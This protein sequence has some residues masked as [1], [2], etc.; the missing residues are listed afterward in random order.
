MTIGVVA[1]VFSGADYAVFATTLLISCGIG[2]YHA[3][4]GGRQRTSAEFF[5]A[6]RSMNPV[7]VAVSLVASFISAI[8]FLGTPAENYIH[9]CMFWLYGI[10]YV[11]TGLITWRC[12]M[13]VF[14][15]LHVT[16]AF[17]YLELRFNKVLR[18]CGM[19]TF[20]LQMIIYMGIVIY[21]PALALSAVTGLHL[22]GS[23]VAIG[24]VCTFYTTIGGMKAVL[25]TDVFQVCIMISGFLA[26][27]IAG[28]MRL[29]G[30]TNVW[31]IAEEGGRIDFFNFDPDPT[32]R[33]TF[34]SVVVGGTFTWS[35]VYCVNQAQ[36][37]RYLT[38]G[39]EPVAQLALFMAVVGMVIVVSLA[40]LAGLVMYANYAGCDPYTLKY[41]DS[42]DQLVPYFLM[43]LFHESPGLPGLLVSAV[44][45][46]ALSTVSSG[47]NSLAAVTGED[48]VKTIRPNI[49]EEKYTKITKCLAAGYGLLCIGMAF[50]ASLLGD[51]L[52]AAL[53]IFG[54]VGGPL[55][56]LFSLAIFF[57]WANSK[58]ALTGLVC[59]LVF[60]FW[61]G[62]GAQI[63]PPAN[64]NKPLLSV[65][66]CP[67]FNSTEAT[68]NATGVLATE[69]PTTMMNYSTPLPEPTER[70]AI[71]QLYAVS[72]AWYSAIAWLTVIGTGLLTSFL[73]GYTKPSEVD[74]RLLCPV[75][76]AMY[77]CLPEK[78]KKPLRCGARKYEPEGDEEKAISTDEKNEKE[79][80]KPD[81]TDKAGNGESYQVVT[82]ELPPP[83]P[84]GQMEFNT[85][86]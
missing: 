81:E 24:L 37:Q 77:C 2:V 49:E 40:C 6:D 85:K 10:A 32:V 51:V 31:N 22:W 72:Y 7:P 45:S 21:A 82:D 73:T 84:N 83:Y 61:I 47:L 3:L 33:H 56:G 39:R 71:A 57:P 23:V 4:S 9:G 46:A 20:F 18:I 86:L 78:L 8:T 36:V 12:F 74:P 29:G 1:R 68:W 62:I 52:Q 43:D 26:L 70:P 53:S 13:P 41:V 79:K 17:E 19:M 75:V 67:V 66:E 11:L 54:I 55:L 59:G 25:W 64:P 30:I 34:W 38:C 35:A 27:I 60:T 28:S 58:G 76:D 14:F 16:S 44:F 63:Y 5:L 15:Q 50:I 48:I 42:T 80:Y 65:D 69:M